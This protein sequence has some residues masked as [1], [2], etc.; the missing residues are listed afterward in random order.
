MSLLD[1][2]IGAQNSYLNLPYMEG[3]QITS[4]GMLGQADNCGLAA[5][6]TE[7]QRKRRAAK[8]DETRQLK[9]PGAYYLTGLEPSCEQISDVEL[10][11]SRP[12]T[13]N[14]ENNVDWCVQTR[15]VD[16][17]RFKDDCQ[18]IDRGDRE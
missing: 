18:R 2:L 16:L 17:D 5:Y 11:L 14:W 13:F 7:E 6:M 12:A 4:T 10:L 9:R 3:S 8:L 1:E 15:G